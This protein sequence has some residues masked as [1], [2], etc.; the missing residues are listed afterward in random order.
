MYEILGIQPDASYPEIKA[1]Y[2]LQSQK[3][4]SER[5]EQNGEDIDFQLKLVNVAF[6]TLSVPAS[7]DAYDAQQ[8]ELYAHAVP[9]EHPSNAIVAL[10]TN[11]EAMSLKAEAMMLR[12]EA[13]SLRADAL[14]IRSGAAISDENDVPSKGIISK[15]FGGLAS[16]SKRFIFMFLTFVAFMMVMQAIFLFVAKQ[17]EERALREEEKIYIRQYYQENGIKI[18]SRAEGEML[19]AERRRAE[20]ERRAMEHEESTS[21]K[22]YRKF[23][24]ESR[25]RGEEISAEVMAGER[26]ARRDEEFRQQQMEEEKRERELAEQRR[27]DRE[28]EKWSRSGYPPSQTD[29]SQA[30]ENNN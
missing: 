24:E 8:A 21:E 27:I 2:H 11:T 4:H 10:P 25:R 18:N 15:I 23:V 13:M 9:P 26:E 19:D 29:N 22:E 20:N 6:H 16:T 14:A 1:A 12:A 30:E 7:R 28:R 17:N 3:L 5:N